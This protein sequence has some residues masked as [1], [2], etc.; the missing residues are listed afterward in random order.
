MTGSKGSLKESNYREFFQNS[1]LQEDIFNDEM[2]QQ[3]V[4]SDKNE[5]KENVIWILN[6]RHDLWFID[7][8]EAHHPKTKEDEERITSDT[9]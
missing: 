8:V 7:S 5:D 3:V 4:K 9:S 2:M 6:C 1:I